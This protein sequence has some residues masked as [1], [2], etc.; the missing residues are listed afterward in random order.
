QRLM[1]DGL[2]SLLGLQPA[3]DV[4]GTAA[5]GREA[6]ELALSTRPDVVL[7]DVRMPVLDGVLATSE[8][9]RQLPTCQ[10]L[11]LTT[12]DDEE[13]VVEALRAGAVGYL[14]KDLPAPDLARAIEAAHKG[15]YQ[16]DP[17]VANKMMK[18]FVSASP[19]STTARS[20]TTGSSTRSV[21]GLPDD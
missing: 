7:M 16:L 12:F 2:A 5:N 3:L 19:S 4:V 11:M 10:V 18:A 9:R 6:I 21:A 20:A 14:L 8:V 17:A 13:Y 1:R 15:I